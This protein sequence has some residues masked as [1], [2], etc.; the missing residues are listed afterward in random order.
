MCQ[1]LVFDTMA[2]GIKEKDKKSEP[3]WDFYFSRTDRQ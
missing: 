3:L 2:G 1:V